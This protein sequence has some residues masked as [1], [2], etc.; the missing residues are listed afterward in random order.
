VIGGMGVLDTAGAVGAGG[1]CVEEV[2]AVAGAIATALG[3]AW[4]LSTIA[5]AAAGGVNRGWPSVGLAGG[6]GAVACGVPEAPA[7]LDPFVQARGPARPDRATV[8]STQGQRAGG[9]LAGGSGVVPMVDRKRSG[10][11]S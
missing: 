9:T 10:A 1:G 11:R 5:G 3:G 2:S 4:G 7:G 6:W 8:A